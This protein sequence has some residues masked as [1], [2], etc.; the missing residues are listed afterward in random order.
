ML[1]KQTL[2]NVKLANES[3]DERISELLEAPSF[4]E[5]MIAAKAFAEDTKLIVSGVYKSAWFL[6]TLENE[7]ESS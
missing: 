6:L 3:G 1:K 7:D 5:A 4:K 2:W